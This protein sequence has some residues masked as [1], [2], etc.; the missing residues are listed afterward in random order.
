[1]LLWPKPENPPNVD[2]M[3][4]AKSEERSIKEQQSTSSGDWSLTAAESEEKK[5]VGPRKSMGF[6]RR[7]KISKKGAVNWKEKGRQQYAVNA[8]C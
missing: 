2:M 1:L 8:M 3:G 7:G 5:R 6:S 4:A